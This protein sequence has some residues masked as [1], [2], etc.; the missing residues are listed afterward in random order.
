M[1]CNA[2]PE[3]FIAV[4][5]AVAGLAIPG[6]PLVL[7]A[8][9]WR[10][11]QTNTLEEEVTIWRFGWLHAEYEYSLWEAAVLLRKA[12]IALLPAMLPGATPQTLYLCATCAFFFAILAHAL[13]LP[14]SVPYAV[15]AQCE[16]VS[17]LCSFAVFACCFFREGLAATS[18]NPAAAKETDGVA[19]AMVVTTAFALWFFHAMHKLVAI[20]EN[21]GGRSSAISWADIQTYFRYSLIPTKGA[22]IIR[23]LRYQKRVAPLRGPALYKR[24]DAEQIEDDRE[25]RSRKG[26][27]A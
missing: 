8:L 19:I 2:A 14:Y 13:L 25:R 22:G 26:A 10:A 20:L 3:S 18:E 5:G 9:V 21:D 24:E 15:T 7:V 27:Q 23:N 12:I 6:I 16:L 4:V 17:L 1:F 11:R